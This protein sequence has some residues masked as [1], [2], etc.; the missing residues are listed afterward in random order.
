D[1][2]SDASGRRAL[3]LLGTTLAREGAPSRRLERR[4]LA[5][6]RQQPVDIDGAVDGVAETAKLLGIEHALG[7]RHEPEVSLRERQ[8]LVAGDR[9]ERRRAA[10]AGDRVEH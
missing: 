5:R 4:Y 6:E 10:R 9:A 7:R 3:P 8:R 1:A 2:D